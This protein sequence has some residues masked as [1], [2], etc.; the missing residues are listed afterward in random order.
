MA[1]FDR[2]NNPI[3]RKKRLRFTTPQF[4]SYQPEEVPIYPVEVPDNDLE[5]YYPKPK[6]TTDDGNGNQS[7]VN[8]EMIV[9]VSPE[10]VKEG[11]NVPL[12][13]TVILTDENTVP[14]NVIE[15]DLL[16]DFVIKGS[17][18]YGIDYE[19]AGSNTSTVSF[20]GNGSTGTRGTVVIPIGESHADIQFISIADEDS[21]GDETII[22][23]LTPNP[24]Y[25]INKAFS[26][27]KGIISE[28]SLIIKLE[29]ISPVTSADYPN[30]VVIDEGNESPLVYRFTPLQNISSTYT[31]SAI[32][33]RFLLGG[34]AQIEVDYNLPVYDDPLSG[35]YPTLVTNYPIEY[36]IEKLN[37]PAVTY[38]GTFTHRGTI[39]IPS[40]YLTQDGKT[41]AQ[42]A[43]NL[44]LYALADEEAEEAESISIAM[45]MSRQY[46]RQP[47]DAVTSYIVTIVNTYKFKVLVLD[48]NLIV[49]GFDNDI[50]ILNSTGYSQIGLV[51]TGDG[52]VAIGKSG[53]DYLFDVDGVQ[54]IQNLVA[55]QF[56][57][58]FIPDFDWYGG[59]MLL[60]QQTIDSE[61]SV[62]IYN[63]VI[64][65][66]A[67]I[68]RWSEIFT[69][70]INNKDIQNKV[71]ND[72]YP[73]GTDSRSYTKTWTQS[74]LSGGTYN[75]SQD[76][77][78]SRVRPNY[79]GSYQTQNETHSLSYTET[80]DELTSFYQL[81]NGGL[82][83]QDSISTTEI[84]AN[85][86]KSWD[87]E[88]K[89][90]DDNGIFFTTT[91][92]ESSSESVVT[93]QPPMTLNYASLEHP[94][95]KDV[96]QNWVLE[97]VSNTYIYKYLFK[98][99]FHRFTYTNFQ[100]FLTD[101]YYLDGIPSP[102]TGW[103]YT[104]DLE[105]YI[106]NLKIW[107]IY[108]TTINRNLYTVVGVTPDSVNGDSATYKINMG[109]VESNFIPP[110]LIE[111]FEYNPYGA[112]SFWGQ[113]VPDE[114]LTSDFNSDESLTGSTSITSTDLIFTSNSLSLYYFN[115]NISSNS[116]I[117][118]SQYEVNRVEINIDATTVI[119]P[120]T[121]VIDRLED[122]PST[123]SLVVKLDDV[124]YEIKDFD[125]SS[126]FN[127]GD[128]CFFVA[129]TNSTELT[130][131]T[132]ELNNYQVGI[133]W[134]NYGNYTKV[135]KRFQSNSVSNP[136]G[137]VTY[138]PITPFTGEGLAV[139]IYHIVSS[140]T[141]KY[142]GTIVGLDGTP[143][144]DIGYRKEE[145]TN[146]DSITL[147]ITPDSMVS[148]DF[149]CWDNIYNNAIIIV[150]EDN[151]TVSLL[152]YLDYSG[153]KKNTNI[154]LDSSGNLQIAIS[155]TPTVST[156][157]TTQL[158]DLYSFPNNFLVLTS[159]SVHPLEYCSNGSWKDYADGKQVTIPTSGKIWVR[160]LNAGNP[161]IV[162]LTVTHPTGL[163]Y[164][165]ES[166]RD[167]TGTLYTVDYVG[168][169]SIADPDSDPAVQAYTPNL[170][171]AEDSVYVMF[172]VI[173]VATID[174]SIAQTID[175]QDG[176]FQRIGNDSSS[177]SPLTNGSN[178][179]SYHP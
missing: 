99:Y 42:L 175:L 106:N 88:P 169:D 123:S 117:D 118:Y 102:E 18:K 154:Y 56:I 41:E 67:T 83:N 35:V 134:N 112:S 13:F 72:S 125:E 71:N 158:V 32:I 162:S 66:T 116:N 30:D 12:V 168:D 96:R 138:H 177:L 97:K 104:H 165:A 139:E 131:G 113:Y 73:N 163:T 43:I 164:T 85:L 84:N 90:Q 29:A 172:E 157:T 86:L 126:G 16:V 166:T 120:T 47:L 94:V 129:S 33:V 178:F 48:G 89:V 95:S 49:Q 137:T 1:D 74:N 6:R 135:L 50:T 159:D 101:N 39:Q 98:R 58:D 93:V 57:D 51:N 115:K 103:S 148:I 26:S 92:T 7:E 114:A 107:Y 110:A 34:V 64:V 31:N 15:E 62:S 3:Y 19:L 61:E 100:G 143:S 21:E 27:A 91:N 109:A 40:G 79:S 4:N 22:V 81:D 145:W 78:Y 149:F 10:A 133:H 173:S 174:L 140:V 122:N 44:N 75:C 45:M 87:K 155:K 146:W 69:R 54:S 9:L 77:S 70:R 108:A 63:P 36:V 141:T 55:S 136:N 17:A 153:S 68:Y 156:E 147:T 2:W 121:N 14:I 176:G 59:I 52:Y 53:D 65:S 144:N 170:F 142:R 23:A 5:L 82:T 11:S 124:V 152:N 132:Y 24:T 179:I 127:F 25:V 128:R 37:E 161:D 111:I 28:D 160:T 130:N 150:P 119:R 171:V 151:H 8:A 20:E 60:S 38:H 76:Y 105:P 46:Y 80:V 167:V